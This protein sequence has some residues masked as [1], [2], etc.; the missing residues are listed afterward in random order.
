MSCDSQSPRLYRAKAE[1]SLTV[2]VESDARD[3]LCRGHLIVQT[4]NGRETVELS[5]SELIAGVARKFEQG[6]RVISFDVRTRFAGPN[7]ES[8]KVTA[9]LTPAGDPATDFCR[10][11]SGSNSIEIKTIVGAMV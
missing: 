6:V 7:V 4:A 2:R 10:L 11:V 9:K 3:Y 5:H 8:A 1:S